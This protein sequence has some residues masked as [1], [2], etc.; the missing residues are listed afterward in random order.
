MEATAKEN[1][2]TEAQSGLSKVIEQIRNQLKSLEAIRKNEKLWAKIDHINLQVEQTKE[3]SAKYN[4][5]LEKNPNTFDTV[6]HAIAI[7]SKNT[8]IFNGAIKETVEYLDQQP[9]SITDWIDAV[10]INRLLGIPIFLFIMWAIFQL[11]F[12]LGEYPM[13]WIESAIAAL[14]G[15]VSSA[16]PEGL[17]SSLLV[18]GIIAGVGGVISF[19][20]NIL[21]LFLGISFLEATGYMARA[22]F[23][24]DRLMHKI[25]LHGKSF[26]PML[27]GFGC[28]VPAF[29]ACRTL[30]NPADRITTMLIIPFMSCGAKLPVHLLLIGA[31]FPEHLSGNV[32]FGV[33]MFG[34]FMALA[35]RLCPQKV[36]IQGRV[37]AFCHGIAA[38]SCADFFLP[39]DSDVD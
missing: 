25:G 32:L 2:E 31:F 22:A 6:Y 26:I 24:V 20:P 21:L 4:Q 13:G 12:K 28:S 8:D 1:P 17:F 15:F 23:V 33:Y 9:K 30:K 3:I 37:R 5:L 35:V 16:L 36:F 11:T 38:L 10:L 29:M 7:L 39:A 14:S 18:D 34:I 19:L 27:T